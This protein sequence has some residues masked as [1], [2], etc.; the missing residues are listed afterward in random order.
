MASTQLFPYKFYIEIKKSSGDKKERALMFSGK[1][2]FTKKEGSIELHTHL[3]VFLSGELNESFDIENKETILSNAHPTTRDKNISLHKIENGG[4]IKG[5]VLEGVLYLGRYGISSTITKKRTNNLAHSRTPDEAETI[6]LYFNITFP[7]GRTDGICILESYGRLNAKYA[8]QSFIN[9]K[10]TINETKFNI[11]IEN[12]APEKAVKDKLTKGDLKSVR[13]VTFYNES[14]PASKAKHNRGFKSITKEPLLSSQNLSAIERIY[15]LSPIGKDNIGD[16]ITTNFN[17]FQ[18]I[19]K[20][21]GIDEDCDILKL[22]YTFG[23]LSRIV[24]IEKGQ[25]FSCSV[26]ISHLQSDKQ[27][28]VIRSAVVEESE[29]L[30]NDFCSYIGFDRTGEKVL[31]GDSDN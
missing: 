4:V 30:A 13:T 1:D 19:G 11:Y 26:D 7:L 2:D 20:L 25:K 21:F 29:E 15:K 6:P 3:F 5:Y 9:S 17:S 14:T 8:L 10:L 27:G 12:Y 24:N 28:R 16:L 23:K 18:E 31:V 22:E